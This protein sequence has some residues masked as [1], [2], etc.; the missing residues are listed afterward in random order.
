MDLLRLDKLI[1]K[2]EKTNQLLMEMNRTLFDIACMM[3]QG[4]IDNGAG[5]YKGVPQAATP[6]LR[7]GVA[8][9]PQCGNATKIPANK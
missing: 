5:V 1:D 7:K 6:E 8:N 3:A 2:Q 9:V 4:G